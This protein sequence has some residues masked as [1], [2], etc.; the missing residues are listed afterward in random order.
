[1]FTAFL[2]CMQPTGCGLDT[3]DR[4][5]SEDRTTIPR[6]EH[7]TVCRARPG[8]TRTRIRAR[9]DL[10]AHPTCRGQLFHDWVG[11]SPATLSEFS[12]ESQTLDYH[13]SYVLNVSLFSNIGN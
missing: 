12:R 10:D 1:M 3:P 11:P 7:A 13:N 9:R 4:V 2:G 6:A 8:T 5:S